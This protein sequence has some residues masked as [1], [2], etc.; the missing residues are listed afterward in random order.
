MP[1]KCPS[2][3]QQYYTDS[4]KKKTKTERKRMSDTKCLSALT[5]ST[6]LKSYY[7]LSLIKFKVLKYSTRTTLC[8]SYCPIINESMNVSLGT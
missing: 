4:L 8:L 3:D 1:V 2:H 6:F 7:I 5:I